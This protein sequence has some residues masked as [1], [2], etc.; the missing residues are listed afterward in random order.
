MGGYDARQQLGD[1]I[2]RRAP[3]PMSARTLTL[4]AAQYEQVAGGGTVQAVDS[5]GAVVAVYSG[6]GGAIRS[7]DTVRHLNL[8]DVELADVGRGDPWVLT[9]VYDRAYGWTVRV[10]AGR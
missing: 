6:V 10:E 3:R 2:D 1:R 5:D 7:P 4:T 8:T 9:D